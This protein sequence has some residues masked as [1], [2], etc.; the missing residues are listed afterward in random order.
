MRENNKLGDQN[1]NKRIKS[2]L[3][4]LLIFFGCIIV[5]L[6]ASFFYLK[7]G[8]DEKNNAVAKSESSVPYQK[9]NC[10]N[11]CLVFCLDDG[12]AVM[13]YLDF[14][15]NKVISAVMYDYS[16]KDEKTLGYTA[17]FKIYADWNLVAGIID[18]IGGIEL[19]INGESLRL[20]GVQTV[21]LISSGGVTF[22]LYRS[23]LLS[24]Y[25]RIARVGLSNADLVYIIENG[26]TDMSMPD[27]YYWQ[28]LLP[29]L[30][31]RSSIIN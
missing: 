27:C 31:S 22:D 20:T 26:K 6:S 8:L 29:E 2:A 14:S 24:V 17:D 11:T 13:I 18:R 15:S 28:D 23:I 16:E 12:S 9:S 5:F 21:D 4:R 30:F 19:D 25:K 1:M 7:H 10:E 3:K